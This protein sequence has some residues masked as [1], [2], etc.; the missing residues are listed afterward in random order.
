MDWGISEHEFWEM[1][2]SEIERAIDSKKRQKKADEQQRAAYDYILADLIG[3][4]VARIYDKQNEFPKLSEVYPAL[5]DHKQEQEKQQQKQDQL[6]AA[7]F[8]AFANA[9]NKSFKGAKTE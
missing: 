1:T 5:F 8:R 4:S 7:R 3:R 2:I 6:S 9:F